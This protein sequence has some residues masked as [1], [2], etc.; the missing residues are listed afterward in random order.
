ML[1]YLDVMVD[2]ALTLAGRKRRLVGAMR[3]LARTGMCAALL[4][5]SAAHADTDPAAGAA[6]AD[7]WNYKLTPSYY[8]TSH[9]K[10]AFD[11]NLRANRGPHAIWLGY[12]RRGGE[13]EQARTGYEY[14]A[15][16]PFGQLVPSLQLATHGFVG[17]RST[18][19]S[20]I[21]SM[22]Y[23]VWDEP[24]RATTTT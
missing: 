23:S 14:T 10:D 16:L 20:A 1:R 17:A 15:Q 7:A 22:R 21:R 9:Q 12:Y 13:F 8:A 4:L 3:Q 18:P 6:A 19:S 24:T 5:D 2:D 11:L